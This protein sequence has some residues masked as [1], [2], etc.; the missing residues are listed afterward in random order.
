MPPWDSYVQSAL[1]AAVVTCNTSARRAV[2]FQ[3]PGPRSAL[4]K[5][6]PGSSSRLKWRRT[7]KNL[8][9]AKCLMGFRSSV[10]VEN[11]LLSL[12]RDQRKAIKAKKR[13]IVTLFSLTDHRPKPPITVFSSDTI[14][15]I[16]TWEPW[17]M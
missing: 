1:A 14:S 16:Q 13:L 15:L 12:S 7:A 17:M 11:K 6:L 5:E 9:T 2:P 4:G 8:I 10:L 3:E